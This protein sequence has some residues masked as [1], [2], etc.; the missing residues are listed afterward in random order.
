MAKLPQTDWQR[1]QAL[2]S[3]SSDAQA[4]FFMQVFLQD[5]KAEGSKFI[6]AHWI[7]LHFHMIDVHAC[8]HTCLHMPLEWPPLPTHNRGSAVNL[9]IDSTL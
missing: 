3:E 2:R 8:N 4:S 9:T 7:W 5:I 1:L 6:I